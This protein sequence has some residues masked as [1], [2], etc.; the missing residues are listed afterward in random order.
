MNIVRGD[1]LPNGNRSG[2]QKVQITFPVNA[3]LSNT[4]KHVNNIGKVTFLSYIVPF[5]WLT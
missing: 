4:S 2:F 1:V 5:D 3:P